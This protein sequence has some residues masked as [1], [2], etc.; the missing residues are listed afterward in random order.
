M[1]ITKDAVLCEQA[2]DLHTR[3]TKTNHI[4]ID[5]LT[6][7]LDRTTTHKV[8]EIVECIHTLTMCHKRTKAILPITDLH[9]SL[10]QQSLI[11]VLNSIDVEKSW[12]CNSAQQNNLKI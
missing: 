10:N 4:G 12:M 11:K 8:I 5:L 6:K 1:I 2:L 3:V 7:I 9:I